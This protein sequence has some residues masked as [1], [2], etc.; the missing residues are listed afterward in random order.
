MNSSMYKTPA[1]ILFQSPKPGGSLQSSLRE[2]MVRLDLERKTQFK[3][4]AYRA[5]RVSRWSE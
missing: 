3:V 4:E 5:S 2:I 1:R